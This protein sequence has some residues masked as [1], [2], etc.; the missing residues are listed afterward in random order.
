MRTVH[1][2]YPSTPLL[3]NMPIIK[4]Q[5][6][7]SRLKGAEMMCPL[8]HQPAAPMEPA[9]EQAGPVAAAGQGQNEGRSLSPQS[10]SAAALLHAAD[11]AEG[12]HTRICESSLPARKRN[13]GVKGT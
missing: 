10:T 8:F 9:A 11:G 1:A 2:P 4:Y 6:G 12:K 3:L 5:L 7:L 13:F